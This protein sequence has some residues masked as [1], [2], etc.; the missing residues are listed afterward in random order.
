MP[1]AINS[2][3]SLN[4]RSSPADSRPLDAEALFGVWGVDS[5]GASRPA[6]PQLAAL[7]SAAPGPAFLCSAPSALCVGPRSGMKPLEIR[8][9]N[10]IAVVSA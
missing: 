6:A 7:P 8:D 5:A 2:D 3:I 4:R 1:G 10:E 9:A